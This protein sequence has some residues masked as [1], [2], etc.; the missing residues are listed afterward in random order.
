MEVNIMN[1]PSKTI[2]KKIMGFSEFFSNL[3]S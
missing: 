1:Q 2:D 3:L